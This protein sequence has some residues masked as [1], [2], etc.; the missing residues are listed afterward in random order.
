MEMFQTNSEIYMV[1]IRHKLE[2]HRLA[3]DNIYGKECNMNGERKFSNLFLKI[4]CLSVN[5]RQFN[6]ASK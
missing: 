2:L 4:E 3:A 1:S 6:V 5:G